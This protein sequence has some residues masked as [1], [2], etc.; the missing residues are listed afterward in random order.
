MPNYYV[1]KERR[2]RQ[3][4]IFFCEYGICMEMQKN[5]YMDAKNFS[6]W[7][8]FFLNYHEDT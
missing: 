6:K 4:F 3:E 5:G 7:I 2:H 8:D 1:F